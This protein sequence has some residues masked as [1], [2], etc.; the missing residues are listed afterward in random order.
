MADEYYDSK[1]YGKALTLYTH[2]LWDFRNEKWWTIVSVV[3]E[4]AIL[5][6]YLTANVQDYILLAFEI[7]GVNINT[8]L[9]EKRKIYDNLI[10]ILKVSM[11][12]VTHK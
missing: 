1:D 4:K 2:M 11:F 9:N 10:R 5:C 6:S 12:C 3:L 8:P 7:L